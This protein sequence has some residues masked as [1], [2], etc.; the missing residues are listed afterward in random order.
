VSAAGVFDGIDG[1]SR[2][3]QRRNENGLQYRKCLSVW[4]TGSDAEEKA[5]HLPWCVVACAYPLNFS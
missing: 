2:R 5:I 3:M 1:V 4:A